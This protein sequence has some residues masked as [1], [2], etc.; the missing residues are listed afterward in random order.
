MPAPKVCIVTPAPPASRAGNRNTALRWARILRRLGCRV[1]IETRWSGRA[2]DLFVALHARKS[3]PSLLDFRTRHPLCPAVLALTGTDLY[4]DIREDEDA[5]RTL[6]LADRLVVL[7]EEALD[8]LTPVQRRKAHVIHQS[9][10]TTLRHAP[11][12]RPFRICVLGHLREEKDPFRIVAAL[13]QMPGEAL[14]VVQAGAALSAS[15]ARA[16]KRHM[17]EDPRYRWLGDLPHWQAMRLLSRSH[18]MVI[19]SLM[20]GGAHVVSEAI[21]LGVPVIASDIPGNRGLLSKDYPALFPAGDEAALAA[22]IRRAMNDPAY[23]RTL[24][25]AVRRKG[26]LTDRLAEEHAW[27]K[28][29]GELGLTPASARK[30]SAAT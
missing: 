1:T 27:R 15:M 4:R 23:L 18:A 12:A 6:D 22:L 9:V 24:G 8:E 3:R 19:S 10:E 17:R 20:E 16:A 2:C 26:N 13:R 30:R 5:A 29:L 25:S 14:D 11:P 7:Q 21:A 28:M